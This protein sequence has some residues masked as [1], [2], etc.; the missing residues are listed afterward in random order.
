MPFNVGA[1]ENPTISLVANT[2]NV[3]DVGQNIVVNGVLANNIDVCGISLEIAY[4]SS[5]LEIVSGEIKDNYPNANLNLGQAGII[6][7]NVMDLNVISNGT[8]YSLT[9]KAKNTTALV[10]KTSLVINNLVAG[11]I[12]AS[13]IDCT[14]VNLDVAIKNQSVISYNSQAYTYDGN[15]KEL[16][17][18]GALPV[19]S[20]VVYSNN[21]FTNAGVYNAVAT[22]SFAYDYAT[23][24][25]IVLNATLTINKAEPAYTIPT[26]QAITYSPTGKLSNIVLPSGWAWSN[27]NT[28]PTV[29]VTSYS[30]IF[31]PID[32]ANYNLVT[33]NVPLTVNKADITGIT[34]SNA[35]YT[36]NGTQRKLL[37]TGSLPTG[38]SVA[39]TNNTATNA[40]VYNAVATITGGTNYKNKTLNATLTINKADPTYTI[41]TLQ[42]ITYSPTVKLSNII[43]PSGWAWSN[44]NTVPTVNVTSYSAIFTPTDTLNY[45]QLTKN[46]PLTVNK[47]GQSMPSTSDITI[48]YI[49]E[50]ISF[51]TN[52]EANLAQ[53]FSGVTVLTNSVITP[54][55]TIYVSFKGDTNYNRGTPLTVAIPARPSAPTAPTM[56]SSIAT[57]ITLNT[58][59]G[60]EYKCND[61]AWQD[62]PIFTGLTPQQSYL[63][64]TRIKATNES[65]RSDVSPSGSFSTYV[66]L[67]VI[68]NVSLNDIAKKITANFENQTGKTLISAMAFLSLYN[69]EN[70]LIET[71][72]L[73]ITNLS[74]DTARILDF[75]YTT[76][77][78][79]TKYKIFVW[80]SYLSMK[81]LTAIYSG[82][83]VA[84]P[85]LLVINNIILNSQSRKISATI[86]NDTG[87][88]ITS[89]VA[90]MSLYNDENKLIETILLDISNLS[91]NNSITIDFVYKTTGFTKYKIFVWDSYLTMKPLTTIYS[92]S[93]DG[94]TQLL[95]IS[96][97]N[98]DLIAKTITATITNNTGNEVA[99][100]VAFMSLY[101][102]ENKL[103]ENIKLDIS[104]LSNNTFKVF[105]FV[106]KTT[107]D[108]T[109]Y[110]IFVWDNYANMKPLSEYYEGRK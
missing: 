89:A 100:A 69:N 51:N 90:F 78:S 85:K 80:D 64:Y 84:P 37:I 19:G 53:D 83:F 79:F 66:N 45:N 42:E 20:N 33:K 88:E 3:V 58:I 39:Y 73:D 86:V 70:R 74:N 23:I 47:A 29:N 41:P 77:S 49:S 22:I 104:S 101:N 13:T 105:D 5:Q 4:D 61:G 32:T 27:G 38:A 59:N 98:V 91:N 17:I 52:L 12:D 76:T 31:T 18:T 65:F 97:T 43:L 26:L 87:S 15:N 25:N 14:T 109:K 75:T 110:K 96:S 71:I 10:T 11:D 82:N 94:L 30:A 1:I 63:F 106:Y 72:K 16:L 50:T 67:S 54:N 103:I 57:D 48:D 55:S 102:D 8:I 34:Y 108:F 7:L 28:V 36:Y 95:S 35:A 24:S 2:S 6:S 46:I 99:S 60:A 81:P 56:Q 93:F 107:A 92:G 62:S 21:K 9:F 68:N 44:G 40:G